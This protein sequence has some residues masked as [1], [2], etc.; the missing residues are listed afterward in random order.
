MPTRM[1][2]L[3]AALAISLN[4]WA[5]SSW[6]AISVYDGRHDGINEYYGRIDKISLE[7]LLVKTDEH[8]MFKITDT[9]WTDNEG[10]VVFMSDAKK[11][12]RK[13][14]Y[15]NTVYFKQ[16]SIV[17]IVPLD[18]SYIENLLGR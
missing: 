13:Y 10:T 6:V 8:A 1:L 4:T 7:K 18:N 2:T 12:G 17:R 11:Y 15:T 14:G 16:S 9:F 3:I 5:E